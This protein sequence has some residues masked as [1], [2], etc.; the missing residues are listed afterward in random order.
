MSATNKN[1]KARIAANNGY[2]AKAYDRINIAIPKGM[3]EQIQVKAD[4]HGESINGFIRRL[5]ERELDADTAEQDT[6]RD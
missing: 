2:N 4:Q 5:I 1:S 3:K 6:K